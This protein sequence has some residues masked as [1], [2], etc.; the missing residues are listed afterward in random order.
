M[1]GRWVVGWVVVVFALVSG[2][3]PTPGE[4]FGEVGC[5]G[6]GFN[7]VQGYGD[8]GTTFGDP[9]WDQKMLEEIQIQSWFFGPVTADVYALYEESPQYKNAYATPEGQ[10]LFGYHMFYYTVA[11]YGE[12]AIAG[13]LAHEFGHRAQFSAQWSMLNPM[14]E[15]EADAFSGYYMAIAKRFA[16]SQIEG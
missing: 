11:T 4:S 7:D 10:I 13:V 16:W 9:Y 14:A 1:G 5:H 12:L 3:T 15:L 6:V 2:C 8:I